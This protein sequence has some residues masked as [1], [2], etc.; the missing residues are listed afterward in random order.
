MIKKLYQYA[1]N[2]WEWQK[3]VDYPVVMSYTTDVKLFWNFLNFAYYHFPTS[4]MGIGFLWKNM[5]K[6]A[7]MEIELVKKLNGCGVCYFDFASLDTM[8]DFNL[9]KSFCSSLVQFDE[10][11]ALAE[12]CVNAFRDTA[13]DIWIE[14]G[15]KYT[16]Y[17]EEL[18]FARFLFLLSLNLE[19]SMKRMGHEREEFLKKLRED[20]AVF[21]YLNRNLLLPI[22]RLIE[23]PNREVEYTFFRWISD[24][25]GVREEAKM[26]KKFEKKEKFYPVAINPLARAVFE[27]EKG[28][29]KFLETRA[30]IYVFWV[31]K[32]NKGGKW[33]T[34]RKVKEGLMPAYLYWTIK[35]NFNKLKGV[36][37]GKD[38]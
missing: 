8:V 12:V 5:E 18:D 4:I 11:T 1:Q 35:E 21:E 20:V 34:P 29:K 23:P 30:G 15:L 6:Q 3:V 25:N 36:K 14:E 32:I 9:L 7:G 19:N 24:T 16:N 17:G 10:D 31:K 27:A 13:P 26:V 38:K 28:E 2:W 33:I 37:G 22:G